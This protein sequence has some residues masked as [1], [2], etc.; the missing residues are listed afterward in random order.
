L[1]A[2]QP[3]LRKVTRQP[4]EILDLHVPLLRM[5]AAL[6][7]QYIIELPLVTRL[8]WRKCVGTYLGATATAFSASHR[9]ERV[10]ARRWR[11]TFRRA[12]TL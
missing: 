9:I 12:I 11:D 6:R 5:R 7:Q 4:L 10:A 2:I 8:C 3:Q 1:P